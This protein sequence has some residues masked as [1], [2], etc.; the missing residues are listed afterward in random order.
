M[1]IETAPSNIQIDEIE[2]LTLFADKSFDTDDVD[3][4]EFTEA[5]DSPLTP[6]KTIIL[7][8]DREINEN[9]L[10]ELSDELDHLQK[11]WEEDKVAQVYLQGLSKVGRYLTKEG[12]YAHPNAIKLLLIFFYDFEKIISS[13]NISGDSISALIKADVH[14]F[15]ILQHQIDLRGSQAADL[16]AGEIDA[17]GVGDNRFNYQ[18]V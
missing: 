1:K 17:Q 3:L 2:D 9:I 18:T 10:Q 12:A 7:S 6:L 11:I 5:Q 16:P 8:L 15:K 14:K 4:F 13:H